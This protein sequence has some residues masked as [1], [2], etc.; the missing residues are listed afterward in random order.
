MYKKF[1]GLKNKPFDLRPDPK[2]L[3]LSR[4]HD[5]A[6]THLA[7]GITDSKGFI[8]LTGDVGTGKTTLLNYLLR[9]IEKRINTAIVFNTNVDALTF[10]EL[11]VK[12]FGIKAPDQKKSTLYEV[13]Y[14]FILEE[15]TRGRRSVLIV[16]EA[17]NM[18]TETLEELRMLSNF[19]TDECSLLQIILSGQP[20]LQWRLQQSELAQLT[21][22]V[23][24]QYHLTPLSREDLGNYV[25]HRLKTAGYGAT[26]PL[27][28]EDALEKIWEY[29]RGVPRLISSICD[30]A[31]IYGYAD[32]VKPIDGNVIDR[33]IEDREIECSSETAQA[34]TLSPLASPNSSTAGSELDELFRRELAT[35]NERLAAAEK[36]IEELT[37]LRS[38]AVISKLVEWVK[39]TYEKQ[40]KNEITHE[41]LKARHEEALQELAK[42]KEISTQQI[43][44]F[45][46][47]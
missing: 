23:S 39:E 34:P 4:K 10:L 13:L 20:Q 42:Y 21:Q 28:V 29:T 17:Q 19:E 41:E 15:Y 27:F 12:E 6:L 8:V 31:L 22:R 30:T 32:E 9:K 44:K 45:S 46:K 11:V 37:R 33:V 24:V 35:I 25:G 43:L 14:E 18:P 5:I 36:Q 7:Y 47:K 16:D 3:F 26:D 38:M 2:F 40:Q 1:Y